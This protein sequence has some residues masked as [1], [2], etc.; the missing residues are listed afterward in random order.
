MRIETGDKI[1]ETLDIRHDT[2]D[3]RHEIR[4]TVC[5]MWQEL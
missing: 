1:L 3:R 2:G 5:D 4:Y